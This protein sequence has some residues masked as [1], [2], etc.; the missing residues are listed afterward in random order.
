MNCSVV[1][2]AIAAVLVSA[3]ATHVAQADATC[4][5]AVRALINP[6]A[7]K[8]SPPPDNRFG[9]VV[10]II[11]GAEQRGYSLQTREGSAYFDADKNPISLSFSSGEVFW[12]PDQGKSWNLVNPNSKDV[13]DAV[14]EG[15]KKQADEATNISCAYAID[16]EGRTVNHY[17]ADYK[18]YNTGDA[19][20]VEY[21][22]DPDD[23]FVWRD[24][25]HTKGAA[26][27]I[28]D[29]RAERAPD[30]AL[31]PKPEIKP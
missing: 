29:V 8:D 19:V 1:T 7:T 2:K 21:W 23:G 15:L 24:L 25:N 9:T 28:S 13:M 17:M 27:V 6:S 3:M 18:L 4:E 22:V 30:M 20:H 26:E 31:P 11:N 16:F 10:T 12:S 14:M 5:D